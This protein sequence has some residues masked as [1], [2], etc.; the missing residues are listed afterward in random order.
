MNPLSLLNKLDRDIFIHLNDGPLKNAAI[1]AYLDEPDA[2]IDIMEFHLE[3]SIIIETTSK[4]LP[5]VKIRLEASDFMH[6]T[7]LDLA[8]LTADQKQELLELVQIQIPQQ[9]ATNVAPAKNILR[10]KLAT[11]LYDIG[12]ASIEL[13]LPQRELKTIIPCS[14]IRIV[15]KDAVKTIEDYYWDIQLIQRFKLLHEQQQNGV[16]YTKDDIEFIAENCC[17]GDIKWAQDTIAI[18]LRQCKEIG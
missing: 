12:Q 7:I 2:L 17:D 6:Q 4:S 8:L 9:V 13:G 5:T 3:G 11:N 15:E 1:D 16:R 18:Y 14:E 10:K